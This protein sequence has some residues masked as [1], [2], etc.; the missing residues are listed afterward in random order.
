M[1]I[2]PKF[3]Y[4]KDG[5]KEQ[6]MLSYNDYVKLISKIDDLEDLIALRE[7]REENKGQTFYS[8]DEVMEEFGITPD[9]EITDRRK[10]Q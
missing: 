2:D 10:A 4:D 6:V 8:I 1:K 5:N 3:L 9:E 7:A